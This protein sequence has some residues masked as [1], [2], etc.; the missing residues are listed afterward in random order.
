[1]KKQLLRMHILDHEN[2][3]KNTK[4]SGLPIITNLMGSN[5]MRPDLSD[6]FKIYLEVHKPH[7]A[8]HLIFICRVV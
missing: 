8:L 6:H 3:M 7:A 4:L 2:Q 5:A 1:M